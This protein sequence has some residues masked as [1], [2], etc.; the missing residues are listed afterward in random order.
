MKKLLIIL[1]TI[2]FLTIFPLS[3]LAAD[4]QASNPTV[5]ATTTETT[6]TRNQHF[7]QLLHLSI[8]TTTDNPN[9]VI[10]FTDKAGK[11]VKL[12]IDGQTTKTIKTPYTLPSLGIG[13]HTLTFTFTDDQ[14]TVQT[15]DETI[16]ILPRTPVVQAPDKVSTDTISLKGTALAASQIVLYMSSGVKNYTA[17]VNVLDDGTW[18]YTFAGKFDYGIYNVIGITE[19]SGYASALSSPLVFEL[20]SAPGTKPTTSDLAPIRFSFGLITASN[21]IQNI[22]ENPDLLYLSLLLLVIGFLVATILHQLINHKNDKKLEHVFNNLL[23]TKD[24]KKVE[25]QS[26]KKMTLREKLEKAK[27]GNSNREIETTTEEAKTNLSNTREEENT[28]EQPMIEQKAKEEVSDKKNEER[29]EKKSK[30]DKKEGEKTFS[31]EDF[32]KLYKEDDPDTKGGKETLKPSKDKKKGESTTGNL[33]K[34]ISVTLTSKP[35]K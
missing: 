28:K 24:G 26:Q 29:K 23:N 22:K 14:N 27:G 13:K 33:V 6:L 8:P 1:N 15:F 17:T 20:K 9:Y 25:V 5:A 35:K 3:V 19:M 16:I 30:E 21:L 2:L 10:T 18:T 12:Q 32:L 34:Q 4:V 11:G 7:E 31:K